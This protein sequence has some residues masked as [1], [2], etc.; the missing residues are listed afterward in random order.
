MFAYRKRIK[1]V[2]L[3]RVGSFVTTVLLSMAGTAGA[4]PEQFSCRFLEV[5]GGNQTEAV[6]D[7]V[8]ELAV[9][10][11]EPNR[12]SAIETLSAV[13]DEVEFAGGSVWRIAELAGEVEEYLVILRLDAG[14]V[15][16][17][18]LLFEWTPEGLMLSTMDF[19]RRYPDIVANQFLQPPEAID[20]ES[21]D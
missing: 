16:G 6:P 19:N 4:S 15:S 1:K 2:N 3:M 12:V 5:I 13:L 10:W 20:C 7:M 8:A 21:G 11:P 9:R 14:E 18:R 17:A